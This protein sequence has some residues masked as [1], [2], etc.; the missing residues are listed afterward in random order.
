[1]SIVIFKT[2]NAML[3]FDREEVKEL[4][5]RKRSKYDLDEVTKLL[6]QISA[7]SNETI[8]IPDEPRYFDGI[9][10]DLIAAGNGSVFCKT[11]IKKY[12][13]RQLKPI[14]VGYDGTPFDIK[15]EKTGLIKRLFLKRRKTPTIFGGIAY[16]CPGGHTLISLITWKTF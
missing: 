6:E 1:M 8:M 15:R 16:N 14:K 5:V 7:A 4:I 9:A 2:Q 12:E 3:K 13:S 10:M 11:C